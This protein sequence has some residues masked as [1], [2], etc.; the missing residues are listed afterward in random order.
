MNE[1]SQVAGKTTIAPEVLLTIAKL[2][3]LKV[4]GVSRMA[5][6]PNAVGRLLKKGAAQ[7]DGVCIEVID[8]AVYL[9]LF[10][11]LKNDV[12]VREVSRT[13]Q[14]EVARS[15]TEMV[16]MAV[17]RVNVHVEDIDYPNPHPVD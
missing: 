3:T 7:G 6:I 5:N 16:G 12:N 17:G 15:V 1:P 13:I 10:T 4:G 9:D 14:Q 11:A 2:T 8:D